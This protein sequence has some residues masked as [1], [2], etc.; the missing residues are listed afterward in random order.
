[1][2]LICSGLFTIITLVLSTNCYRSNESY[3]EKSIS[4]SD[5]T[6]VTIGDSLLNLQSISFKKP[7]LFFLLDTSK[8]LPCEYEMLYN[9]E[10]YCSGKNC[11]D[12]ITFGVIVT[13]GLEYV[14][15]VDYLN[16]IHKYTF[17]ILVDESNDFYLNNDFM[18]VSEDIFQYI[19]VNDKD[20]LAVIGLSEQNLSYNIQSICRY[21]ESHFN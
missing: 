9:F 16:S 17:P 7:T 6:R 13:P 5:E 19:Y 15:K 1:M 4:F 14:E 18:N 21:I 20:E 11:G 3:I 10:S 8:C 12:S 2:K